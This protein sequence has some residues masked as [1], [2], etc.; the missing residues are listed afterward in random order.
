MN[1]GPEVPWSVP[2]DAFAGY[3]ASELRTHH[4]DDVL[5]E[6]AAPHLVQEPRERV[7]ECLQQRPVCR[8]F[9]G[10]GVEITQ[11]HYVNL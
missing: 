8:S 7:V 11:R 2:A 10:V 6:T 3:P 1:T 4:D 9:I 5:A